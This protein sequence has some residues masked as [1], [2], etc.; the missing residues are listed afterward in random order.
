MI[1]TIDYASRA[2]IVNESSAQGRLVF[3]W[4]RALNG[5]GS[6]IGPCGAPTNPRAC[7]QGNNVV[8]AA[9]ASIA[10]H[11][12]SFPT[13]NLSRT[14]FALFR[15]GPRPRKAKAMGGLRKAPIRGRLH[16]TI[17]VSRYAQPKPPLYRAFPLQYHD[18][19]A[20]ARYNSSRF[21][22][23]DLYATSFR[24]AACVE[25]TSIGD[26]PKPLLCRLAHLPFAAGKSCG[27]CAFGLSDA[28]VSSPTPF[29]AELRDPLA[30]TFGSG[31]RGHYAACLFRKPVAKVSRTRLR[32]PLDDETRF[33]QVHVVQ[34][35]KKH[36]ALKLP[37]RK[38]RLGW[39]F[40]SPYRLRISVVSNRR[41]CAC[42]PIGGPSSLRVCP[43]NNP[44]VTREPGLQT[45]WLPPAPP[46]P[47]QGPSPSQ[48]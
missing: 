39:P 29:S 12:F 15:C 5:H 25:Q 44:A 32:T 47:L 23:C 7:A 3:L 20:I 14:F 22:S 17:R 2:Q 27:C 37:R 19:F 6:R 30:E 41:S 21:E 4:T 26:H 34:V 35:T 38:C 33:P 8:F 45:P 16:V 40:V 43:T 28:V 18:T 24:R 1:H 42:Q 10:V 31:L 13:P 48:T 36:S 11:S 46:R 9:G